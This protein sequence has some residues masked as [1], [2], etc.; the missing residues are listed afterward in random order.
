MRNRFAVP[1]LA[2]LAICPGTPARADLT[3]VTWSSPDGRT[4][5]I[6]FVGQPDGA[7]RS[8]DH[9]RPSGTCD[10]YP[11]D[12]KLNLYGVGEAGPHSGWASIDLICTVYTGDWRWTVVTAESYVSGGYAFVEKTAD[13][14]DP[15][16]YH[17]C[18]YV[19]VQYLDGHGEGKNECS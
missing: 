2:L 14:L 9:Y 5:G 10:I 11:K 15:L 18:V 12:G 17:I 19:Y 13:W 16:P 3:T 4:A 1:L 6:A 7:R 8:E